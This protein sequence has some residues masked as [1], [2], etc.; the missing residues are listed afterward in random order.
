MKYRLECAVWEITLK[1]NLN[2]IHCGSCAGEKREKE[3]SREEALK[4]CEDLKEA[5]CLSVALMGGEPLLRPDFWD[6]AEKVRALG[7]DLSVITNGTIYK[8]EYFKKLAELKPRA[9]AVSIDGAKKETHEKIRGS[10]GCWEKSWKFI[11]RAI[12]EKLP[13]SL[14]T[15]VSKINISQLKDLSDMIKGKNIAWQIQTAGSEGERFP[16]EYLLS[17]EEFYAVGVFIDWLRKNYTPDIMPVIGAHDLGYY[18]AFLGDLSVYGQWPGCQAGKTVIGIRSSGDVLPC[19]SLN[20][21]NFIVANALDRRIKDIWNDDKIF[22]PFRNFKKEDAGENCRSCD[23]L[24]ECMGGCCEMSLMKTG[25][26]RNDFYCFR[27][28]E[29]DSAQNAID[30]IKLKLAEFKNKKNLNVERLRKIFLGE[31]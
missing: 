2:C 22:A 3:L 20:D 25:K 29:K 10:I 18:S 26:T 8:E 17:R 12:E 13:V 15:T 5:G 30:K 23:K 9:V 27:K 1:C 4:L 28:I 19:L 24:E 7:M 16:K 14:I 6:I 11:N 31:R 21:S